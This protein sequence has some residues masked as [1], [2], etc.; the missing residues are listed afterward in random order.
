LRPL[1]LVG[2]RAEAI[3]HSTMSRLIL[4]CLLLSA[5]AAGRHFKAPEEYDDSPLTKELLAEGLMRKPEGGHPTVACITR[6]LNQPPVVKECPVAPKF[7]EVST[8]CYTLWHREGGMVQQGCM[9]MQDI[10]LLTQCQKKACKVA[11]QV[12][13]MNFC[14]CLGDMCNEHFSA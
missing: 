10:S 11:N 4:I 7:H 1:L 12:M 8:G 2:V 3:R 14:C 9:E 5:G 13:E 6:G